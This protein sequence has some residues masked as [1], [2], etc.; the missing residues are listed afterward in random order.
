MIT[1]IQSVVNKASET[2]L[3]SA[4]AAMVGYLCAKAFMSINPT[5][6]AVVS[7]V[8]VLVS[9]VTNPLFSK[10]F[11]GPGANNASKFLGTVLNIT[12]SV[13]VSAAI[14]TAIGYS[15]SFSAFLYLNAL[16]IATFA[17]IA[18][19]VVVAAR[20]REEPPRLGFLR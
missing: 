14:A 10:I 20:I 12:L 17:S 13:A 6:A 11:S 7:A 19:G 1:P 15:V 18:L 4:T 5:H 3:N 2:V 9:K 16:T 8:A